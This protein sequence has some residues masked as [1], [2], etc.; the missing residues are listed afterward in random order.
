MEGLGYNTKKFYVYEYRDPT[1]GVP[2]YVGKGSGKRYK[3]HVTGTKNKQMSDKINELKKQGLFP[4]IEQI[5]HSDN[6]SVALGVEEHVINSYGLLKE[7]GTLLNI[8]K[9]GVSNKKVDVPQ[10][11]IN[12][13]GKY[14]DRVVGE[15]TGIN[16]YTLRDYRQSL[17][18]PSFKETNT[19]LAEFSDVFKNDTNIYTVYST[20][21]D[22]VTRSR[23][24]L[25]DIL[26]LT[27]TEIDV[28]IRQDN[29]HVKGWSLSPDI[30]ERITQYTVLE[31]E[32]VDGGYFKG[33]YH[34][35]SELINV[36]FRSC[37]NLYCDNCKSLKGWVVKGRYPVNS[38][39]SRGGNIY[40]FI[41]SDG[42]FFKGTRVEFEKN[43]GVL[44]GSISNLIKGKQ[45]TAK[46][47]KLSGEVSL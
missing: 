34:E 20:N 43:E 19:G 21:G 38:V 6:E 11:V 42:R 40:E 8:L 25:P 30:T 7:G 9:R 37:R 31:L 15:M 3:D 5:F 4:V 39:C 32:N 22:V 36:S 2:F 13:L 45:K 1:T 16:Q 10:E 27:S 46:G 23:Y 18:I 47:W 35:F 41:H 33:T 29:S 44:S 17:G 28:L 14:T 24:E 26:E 12:L